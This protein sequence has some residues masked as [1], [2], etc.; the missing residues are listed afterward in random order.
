MELN[1]DRRRFLVGSLA[2]PMGFP[3]GSCGALSS[4]PH[5][6]LAEPVAE[7]YQSLNAD[8]RKVICLDGSH[9]K[10]GYTNNNW[11]ILDT[12]VSKVLKP[13][14][15]EL[16]TKIF[17]GLHSEEFADTVIRQVQEDNECKGIDAISFAFFG[18]PEEA[19]GLSCIF[20]GRHVTRHWE[21]NSI[22]PYSGNLFAGHSSG[23]FNEKPDHAGN[24]W[25]YQSLAANRLFKALPAS[26]QKQVLSQ[27][28]T[29]DKPEVFKG[30]ND[31]L[32]L[33]FAELNAEGLELARVLIDGIISRPYRRRDSKIAWQGIEARGGLK[34]LKIHYF[35]KEDLG[36]DGV[37]DNWEI[38]GP[39]FVYLFRG[40]PHAHC[41]LKV[42]P[43]V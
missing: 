36:K 43:L 40:N 3:L 16:A 39:G 42:D 41:W 10:R 5:D 25:W 29:R 21:P 11:T 7:L 23:N 38:W 24:I 17:R 8:Q 18:K 32:G 1:F 6:E 15:M 33:S 13:S 12:E 30:P 19:K 26:Q 37:W 9:A 2:L 22:T 27:A 31:P 4:V 20:A 34:S 14:Q 28:E 35:Q